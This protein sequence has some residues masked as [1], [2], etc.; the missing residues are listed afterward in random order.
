MSLED[1]ASLVLS[2]D[3]DFTKIMDNVTNPT[4]TTLSSNDTTF[5]TRGCRNG[6]EPTHTA[7]Q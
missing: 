6:E 2:S 4:V 1:A 7:P 5:T 3:F